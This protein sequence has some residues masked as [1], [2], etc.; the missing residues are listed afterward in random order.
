MIKVV[1]EDSVCIRP[2]PAGWWANDFQELIDI[3][4]GWDW[5]AKDFPELPPPSEE[6]IEWLKDMWLAGV[7]MENPHH[8]GFVKFSTE[9]AE[10]AKQFGLPG[11]YTD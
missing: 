1:Y 11:P 9:D 3:L 7:M 2:K 6:Q 4:E 10:V 5:Y 8:D